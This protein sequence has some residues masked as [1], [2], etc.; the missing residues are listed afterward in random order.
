M[1]S[2]GTKRTEWLTREKEKKKA[3]KHFGQRA[4]FSGEKVRGRLLTTKG[5]ANPSD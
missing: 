4:E 3:F 1:T 2:L 5:L